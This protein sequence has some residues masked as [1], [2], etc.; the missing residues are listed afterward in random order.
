MR[1]TETATVSQARGVR[2]LAVGRGQHL[3]LVGCELAHF[4]FQLAELFLEPPH[5]EHEHVIRFL[6]IRRELLG[7][8]CA[9]VD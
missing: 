2:D 7:V 3:R 1:L 9:G 4:L 5:L 8:S 6:P